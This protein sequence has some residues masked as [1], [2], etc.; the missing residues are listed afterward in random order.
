MNDGIFDILSLGIRP[1]L[2][3]QRK[4][5]DIISRFREKLINR[6]EEPLTIEDIEDF[7]S[8]MNNFNFRFV[9]FSDYYKKYIEN[10]NRFKPNTE[11]RYPDITFLLIAIAEDE[12]KPTEPLPVFIYHLK[13]KYGLTRKFF[14]SNLKKK[15]RKLLDVKQKESLN[16]KKNSSQKKW[17]RVPLP[18]SN[19]QN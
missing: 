18:N 5:H 9:F 2:R 6:E 15:N 16:K 4:F 12:W 14:V 7:Y 17:T 19:K 11:D 10:L 8:K 3:K 1:L 13:F